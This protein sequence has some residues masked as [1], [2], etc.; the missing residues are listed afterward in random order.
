MAR[1]CGLASHLDRRKSRTCF[2]GAHTAR[3]AAR[4]GRR[5]CDAAMRLHRTSGSTPFSARARRRGNGA[6]S[7]AQTTDAS[8][9]SIADGRPS[10]I[11]HRADAK[12]SRIRI[13]HDSFQYGVSVNVARLATRT[14]FCGPCTLTIPGRWRISSEINPFVWIDFRYSTRTAIFPRVDLLRDARVRNRIAEA[15][16]PDRHLAAPV[17]GEREASV[18]EAGDFAVRELAPAAR[19]DAREVGRL[20][21]QRR[22][23]RAVS[24]APARHGSSRSSAG[25]PPLRAPRAPGRT[26]ARRACSPRRARAPAGA[27]SKSCAS[28]P[29]SS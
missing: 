20:L 28:R 29:P 2:R 9:E 8:P 12:A 27:G 5:S 26:P 4:W 17:R 16:A 22:R 1:Q 3:R 10:R 6:A 14:A 23:G 25:R 19:G 11:L 21:D 18:D 7:G 15:L 13:R 24:P